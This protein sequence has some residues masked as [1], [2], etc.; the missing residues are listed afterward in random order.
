MKSAFIVPEST[1]AGPGAR[2]GPEEFGLGVGQCRLGQDPRA[3]AACDP[4]AA[5]RHRPVA[6]PVP[7][8]YAGGG[9]EHVEP[10]LRDIELV[11]RAGRCGARGEDRGDLT[12]RRPTHDRL[13]R[14]R[15]LFA[16]ALETPGGLKIQTI[17]AFCE[18]ILHQFPLEANVAGP[19]RAARQP[20]GGRADRG[21]ASLDDRRR[22]RWQRAGT[23]RG[24]RRHSRHQR[25]GRA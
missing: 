8:L 17:H 13:V 23:G 11:D 15:R 6:H 12:A 4:A 7:D 20:D 2:V 21:G 19:F 22:G 24:L 10:R 1:I 9:G 14:A 5:R 16:E 18:A 3:V 25:R